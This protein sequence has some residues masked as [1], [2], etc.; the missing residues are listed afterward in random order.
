MNMNFAQAEDTVPVAVKRKGGA[1]GIQ[2]LACLVL[3]LLVIAVSLGPTTAMMKEGGVGGAIRQGTYLSLLLLGILSAKP[4]N[5]LRKLVSVPLPLVLALLVCAASLSWSAVPGIGFR[6]L[7]L[8]ASIVWTIAILVRELGYER[9]LDV[10]RSAFFALLVANYVAVFAF[11]TVGIH[12]FGDR[13]DIALVG[14]W[15]GIM[16]HKNFAGAIMAFT[17]LAFLFDARRMHPIL[18]F[19]VLGAALGF[20]IMSES[21][22]SVGMLAGAVAIGYV[23]GKTSFPWRLAIIPSLAI[24]SV[25][26][27][28]YFNLYRYAFVQ[29]VNDPATFTGRI[30]IW[31]HMLEYIADNAWYGSGYGS[32][33][34]V[35][36]TGPIFSYST[37]WVRD[38]S[39]GH[40]GYLDLTASLGIPLAIVCLVLLLVWPFVRLLIHPRTVGGR[41]ALLLS[42]LTF[43]AGHN[44]TESSF[45]ERDLITNVMLILTMTLLW[46]LTSKRGWMRA[47]P[48]VDVF[49]PE[50][51]EGSPPATKWTY[52][53]VSP[54]VAAV[55]DPVPPD[56]DWDRN[57]S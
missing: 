36:E 37:D 23:F 50:M 3:F 40:N 35:G 53:R 42:L 12:Q 18:R 48:S 24:G 57:A 28:V 43:C 39:S 33:W 16:G 51:P 27:M 22:T 49:V 17:I 8:T 20:L 34:T 46:E 56:Q 15:C 13:I 30:V 9:S 4:W 2:P 21:K 44:M 41:G 10:L 54:E 1:A 45:L 32:F 6:R 55:D 14:D 52:R 7:I 25:L 31:R 38:I 26:A 5:D 47:N 29:M 19:G 11:P